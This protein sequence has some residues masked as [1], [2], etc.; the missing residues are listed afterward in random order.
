MQVMGAALG[1]TRHI[2]LVRIA[3]FGNLA[4]T[5]YCC[6]H[7]YFPLNTGTYVPNSENEVSYYIL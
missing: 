6:A 5:S 3:S 2:F 1:I 4:L 7:F